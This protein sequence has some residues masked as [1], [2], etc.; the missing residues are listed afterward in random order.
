MHN[1][2]GLLWFWLT[3]ACGFTPHED[4]YKF[5]GMAPYARPDR[6]RHVANILARHLALDTTGL[7]LQRTDPATSIERSWPR[8]EADLKGVRFDDVSGGLQTFTDDLLTTWITNAVTATGARDILAGGGVFMNVKTNQ[9]IAALDCVDTFAAFPSAA[10]KASPSAPSTPSSPSATVTSTCSR[11][12]PATSVR[13]PA[14][15]VS[16]S[17]SPGPAFGRPGPNRSTTQSPNSSPPARSWPGAP[18]AW[19]T[20]HARSAT[21]P[22]SPTP[23]TPTCQVASTD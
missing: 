8:I 14:T 16:A 22:S 11:S 20:G 3:H 17:P 12:R 7:R 18:A 13:V 5:V 21:A 4:E 6:T 2:V 10:T 19:S 15:T 9:R 1:S 23:P